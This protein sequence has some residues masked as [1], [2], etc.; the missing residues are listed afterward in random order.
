M[1]HRGYLTKYENNLCNYKNLYILHR[2][3]LHPGW[4]LASLWIAK[5]YDERLEKYNETTVK[6]FFISMQN[7]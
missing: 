2:T 5:Y 6:I 3:N 1:I 7:F 4:L